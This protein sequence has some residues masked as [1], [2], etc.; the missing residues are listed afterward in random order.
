MKGKRFLS[1]LLCLIMVLGMLPGLAI[2]ASALENIT[3]TVKKSATVQFF[4]NSTKE[5]LTSSSPNADAFNVGLAAKPKG[6]FYNAKGVACNDKEFG[7]LTAKV[8]LVTGGVAT[9]I[10]E[11]TA[12]YPK[13]TIT[14]NPNATLKSIIALTASAIGEYA[15]GNSTDISDKIALSERGADN[16]YTLT[17]NHPEAYQ[18]HMR[19]SLIM[20]VKEVKS[21]DV[22]Y[23]YA[24]KTI[25]KIY[26]EGEPTVPQPTASDLSGI[27]AGTTYYTKIDGWYLLFFVLIKT[28]IHKKKKIGCKNKIIFQNYCF[29]ISVDNFCNTFYNR[30][31]KS[32]ICF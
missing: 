31:T 7:G 11:D 20:E 24:G 25:K 14:V 18:G 5:K 8:A 29:T 16:T 1:L 26:V 3:A 30:I 19:V 10:T 9:E 17:F 2:P 28:L 27:S 4:A 21:Y 23:H 32:F 13:F 22:T 6:T 12:Y 15:K